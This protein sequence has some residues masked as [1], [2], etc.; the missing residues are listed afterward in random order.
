M[1]SP[2]MFTS[3]H[4]YAPPFWAAFGVWGILEMVGQFRQQSSSGSAGRDRGSQFML[5]G[6][7]WV[8]VFLGFTFAWNLP[9][10]TI[11]AFRPLVF[12]LGVCLT[13]LGVALRW[14]SIRVLGR[15]FS[16]NLAVKTDQTVVERGPYRFVRHPAYSGTLLTMLGIGLAMTNWASLLVVLLCGLFG[17]LYRVRVEEKMLVAELGQPYEEYMRRTRRFTPFVF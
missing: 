16:R 5:V 14:W 9:S 12:Y 11:T 15:Y 8:G 3:G 2:L 1:M 13:L 10:A 6:S 17:H 7:L 4:F